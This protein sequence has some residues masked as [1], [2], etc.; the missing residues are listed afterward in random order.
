MWEPARDQVTY[1]VLPTATEWAK[2]DERPTSL[3]A[4]SGVVSD[5]TD[6]DA[7]RGAAGAPG[8]RGGVE[9]ESAA[10]HEAPRERKRPRGPKHA[11]EAPAPAPQAAALPA[12]AAAPDAG[13]VQLAQVQSTALAL[14]LCTS[15]LNQSAD[16]HMLLTHLTNEMMF[17]RGMCAELSNQ[18]AALAHTVAVQLAHSREHR[19]R[20]ARMALNAANMANNVLLRD[21]LPTNDV[22]R[23]YPI[24]HY[25]DHS[26]S[27]SDVE[28]AAPETDHAGAAGGAGPAAAEVDAGAPGFGPA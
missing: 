8:A 23:G 6:P 25:P 27:D 18:N 14:H 16:N 24:G 9:V 20:A 13:A 19:A 5:P 28:H 17:L 4:A 2:H 1:A 21:V 10:D 22:T 11:A 26:S 7:G 15:A 3:R 12:A